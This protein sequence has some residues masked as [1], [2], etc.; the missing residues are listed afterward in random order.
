M[1][2]PCRRRYD[3]VVPTADLEGGR[4]VIELPD[5]IEGDDPR[6][7]SSSPDLIRANHRKKWWCRRQARVTA[8]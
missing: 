4:V 2:R 1:A 7:Q 5:E 3:A 8:Q 6:L